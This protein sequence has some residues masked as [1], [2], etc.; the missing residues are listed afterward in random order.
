VL[1]RE[2]TELGIACAGKIPGCSQWSKVNFWQ[3][4]RNFYA[5][6]TL[7]NLLFTMLCILFRVLLITLVNGSSFLFPFLRFTLL[8]GK[9]FHVSF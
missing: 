2:V 3:T 9:E 7:P 5:L 6:H 1:L 8:P 4:P